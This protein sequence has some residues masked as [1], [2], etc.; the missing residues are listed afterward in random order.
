MNLFIIKFPYSEKIHFGFSDRLTEV[1]NSGFH[2]GF[3]FSEFGENQ[4]ILMIPQDNK[5]FDKER[6][7]GWIEE[8]DRIF[9]ENNQPYSLPTDERSND[10]D[11]DFLSEKEEHINYVT[12]IIAIL[13]DLKREKGI[14]GKIVAARH[15]T[16]PAE[17]D[18]ISI[19]ESLKESY[20]DACVFLFSTPLFGT[21][22]GASPELLLKAEDNQ[23]ETISLAGTR[24]VTSAD[25]DYIAI[26]NSVW[27]VV[28][29][30]KDSGWDV[31][32]IEE[33]RIV[34][35]FILDELRKSDIATDVFG[36][37]TRRAGMVEHLQTSIRGFIKGGIRDCFNILNTLSPTPALC[38]Y[39]RRL[40]LDVITRNENFSR[41]C[42]GGLIGYI[43]ENNS[44]ISENSANNS[45]NS[46]NITSFVNLRSGIYNSLNKSITLFAGG[47]I[48][49]KS[50]P[51][52][53]WN[54]T[55][56]KLSTML[57]TLN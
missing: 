5:D 46:G 49:D 34:T 16:F 28:V 6:Y 35:N 51:L 43:S 24:P 13:K 48:T 23:M 27:P 10:I 12:K 53:E 54:E 30:D 9:Y 29:D 11:C 56:R 33:Q 52:P 37:Y 50:D 2:S 20:P 25:V 1:Y 19:F 39:P 38:G 3:I 22:I 8:N 7:N 41:S 31:K 55:N 57:S 14:S 40:S 15:H 26:F 17:K 44:D 42:Y 36:P 47:G 4:Q 32:N 18:P 21:W 45:L